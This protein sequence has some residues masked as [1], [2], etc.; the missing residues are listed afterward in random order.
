HI[1][2]PGPYEVNFDYYSTWGGNREHIII[3]PF[4]EMLNEVGSIFATT[5]KLDNASIRLIGNY[6]PKVVLRN[7]NSLINQEFESEL[8]YFE[9]VTDEIGSVNAKKYWKEI[10][11]VS[12]FS[13]KRH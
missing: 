1:I 13:L 3:A 4:S 2:P 6:I 11:N 5:V 7:L 10:W 12:T 8:E 9:A